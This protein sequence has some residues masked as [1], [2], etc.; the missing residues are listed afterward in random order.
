MVSS[1]RFQV[2]RAEGF[3]LGV[4]GFLFGKKAGNGGCYQGG[5]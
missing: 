1:F 3:F 2:S 5:V 4:G